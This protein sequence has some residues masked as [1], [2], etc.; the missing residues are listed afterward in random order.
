MS[1]I[2]M[3]YEKQIGDFLVRTEDGE[4]YEIYRPSPGLNEWIG[5]GSV[6]GGCTADLG[7]NQDSLYDE[8]E[9]WV[10]KHSGKIYC[11]LIAGNFGEAVSIEEFESA[12][13][14]ELSRQY[15]NHEIEI[16][17]QNASGSGAYYEIN[18]NPDCDI[19]DISEEVYESLL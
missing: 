6:H 12:F 15:P 16:E 14:K 3:P 2:V 5:S 8:I 13:R 10:S 4:H 17:I 7:D 9:S 19:Q 1:K 18:G 11:R